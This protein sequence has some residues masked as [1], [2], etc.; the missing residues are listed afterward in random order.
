MKI[1]FEYEI[2]QPKIKKYILKNFK[3]RTY[4]IIQKKETFDNFHIF[5]FS[6]KDALKNC[7][8]ETFLDNFNS[9]QHDDRE[10]KIV[11]QK[12]VK[13]AKNYLL[14]NFSL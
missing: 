3:N 4:R 14:Q 10:L 6:D 12:F 11:R 7:S 2:L 8:F 9:L 1:K 13:Y 5:L